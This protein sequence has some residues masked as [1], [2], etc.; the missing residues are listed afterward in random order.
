MG[1]KGGQ[2]VSFVD[3]LSISDVKMRLT[4]GDAPLA[5]GLFHIQLVLLVLSM[6]S[7]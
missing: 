3:K 7:E 6:K 2:F 5:I 1:K 4:M